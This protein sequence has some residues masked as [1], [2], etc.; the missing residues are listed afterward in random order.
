MKLLLPS[1]L[2]LALTGTIATAYPLTTDTA[3][4][5]VGT[6]EISHGGGAKKLSARAVLPHEKIYRAG[7][8]PLMRGQISV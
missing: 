2:G 6:A 3:K 1:I 5:W 8:L 7:S 4:I